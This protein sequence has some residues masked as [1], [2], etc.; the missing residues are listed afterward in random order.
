M[1]QVMKV[2]RV[3]SWDG[4]CSP[5][6]REDRPLVLT[7]SG[8][9]GL[10]AWLTGHGDEDRCLLLTCRV[11][12]QWQ[13]VPRSEED[14]PEV[15]AV[16]PAEV[17]VPAPRT[18]QQPP[19]ARTAPLDRNRRRQTGPAS[20]RPERSTAA[21]RVPRPRAATAPP[22]PT[23]IALPSQTVLDLL[24]SGHQVVLAQPS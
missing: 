13:V 10:L 5:C 15:A 6:E 23:S 2:A 22:A 1:K 24:A 18:E 8:P 7:R 16:A 20:R 17:H 3:A 4:W 9:A 12:G 21:G 11:C 14:D 19:T